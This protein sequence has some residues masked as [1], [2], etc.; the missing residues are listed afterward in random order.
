MKMTIVFLLCFISHA[1]HA[2]TPSCSKDGTVVIYSNGLDSSEE[3]TRFASRKLIAQQNF[4][5]T[6]IDLGAKEELEHVKYEFRHNARFSDNSSDASILQRYSDYVGTTIFLFQNTAKQ[7]MGINYSTAEVIG[8][9]IELTGQVTFLA[10]AVNT[11]NPV[12]IALTL[13]HFRDFLTGELAETVLSMPG[14]NAAKLTATYRGY[15]NEG[16]RVL[17]IAHGEGSIISNVAYDQTFDPSFISYIPVTPTEKRKIFAST[18][19][20]SA[21]SLESEGVYRTYNEDQYYWNTYAPLYSSLF[22]PSPNFSYNPPPLGDSNYHNFAQIYLAVGVRG[23]R[24]N[25]EYF[26]TLGGIIEAAEKLNSDCG[27]AAVGCFVENVPAQGKWH[28][29]PDGS[30]GG[31]VANSAEVEPT[32]NIF[33]GAEVCDNARILGNVTIGS[34]KV[35]GGSVLSGNMTIANSSVIHNSMITSTGNTMINAVNMDTVTISVSNGNFA[36][37]YLSSST[38]TGTSISIDNT[39]ILN[40]TIDGNSITILSFM[41]EPTISGSEILTTFPFGMTFLDSSNITSSKV[42]DSYVVQSTVTSSTISGAMLMY[43]TIIGNI[44]Q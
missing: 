27:S 25:D 2:Y 22:P 16:K 24:T 42:T 37:G 43:Q 12:L 10:T 34:S 38:I 44:L 1:V 28:Q 3:Q 23:P 39:R 13:K 30:K 20:G 31:F 21:S 17:A 7:L 4:L 8:F 18:F 6:K 29:N 36:G 11:L 9:V 5:N 40:S 26:G 32:V 41:T 15:L 35:S 14:R 19:V 33:E